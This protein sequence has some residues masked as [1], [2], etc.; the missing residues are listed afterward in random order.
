VIEKRKKGAGG[1]PPFICLRLASLTQQ[2]EF[3]HLFV[4]TK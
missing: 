1:R 2:F 3:R 4:A